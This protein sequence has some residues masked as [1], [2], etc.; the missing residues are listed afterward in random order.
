MITF[1]G[2]SNL[3]GDTFLPD[4]ITMIGGLISS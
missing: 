3:E 1:G 4:T 2:T